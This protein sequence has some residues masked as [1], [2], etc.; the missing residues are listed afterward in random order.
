MS[1]CKEAHKG[2]YRTIVSL[3]FGSNGAGTGSQVSMLLGGGRLAGT[4]VS[5]SP[6]LVIVDTKGPAP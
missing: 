3:L 5:L 2:L 1:S 4:S 6:K